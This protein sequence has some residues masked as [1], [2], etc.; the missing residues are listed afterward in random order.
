MRRQDEV[1]GQTNTG[2]VSRELCGAKGLWASPV[3]LSS[4]MPSALRQAED[5]PQALSTSRV[6]GPVLADG[7]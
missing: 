4:Q 1:R 3:Q 2:S 6:P 7:S 5:K